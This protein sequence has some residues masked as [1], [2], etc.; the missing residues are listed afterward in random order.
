MKDVAGRVVISAHDE[1]TALTTK[2]AFFKLHVLNVSAGAAFAGGALPPANLHDT[3]AAFGCYVFKNSQK[4][5]KSE[6]AHL[7]APQPLHTGDVQVLKVQHVELIAQ[8]MG[9]LEMMIPPLIGNADVAPGKMPRCLL[10]VLRAMPLLVFAAL[11]LA[12]TA[13]ILLVE[14]GR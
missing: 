6:V 9:E 4:L 8:L 11:E 13:Q 12:D 14:L 5:G 2:G 10:A 7:P 1:A 3:L